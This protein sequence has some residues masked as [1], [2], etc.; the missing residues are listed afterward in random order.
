VFRIT[1]GPFFL[2]LD[3]FICNKHNKYAEC[4]LAF[5]E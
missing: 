2:L 4:V 1:E 3:I 5:F